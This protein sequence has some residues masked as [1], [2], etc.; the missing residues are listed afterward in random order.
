MS[1]GNGPTTERNHNPVQAAPTFLPNGRHVSSTTPI[2]RST[3]GLLAASTGNR[4]NRIIRQHNSAVS[5]SF[6]LSGVHHQQ[7]LA[8]NPDG[9]RGIGGRGVAYKSA[10]LDRSRFR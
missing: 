6:L 8:K 9:Y 7:Y 5:W 1:V 4:P 2:R 3:E 10:G